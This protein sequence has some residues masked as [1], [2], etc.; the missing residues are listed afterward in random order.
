MIREAFAH[1]VL[2]VAIAAPGNNTANARNLEVRLRNV[3]ER[4]L[5]QPFHLFASCDHGTAQVAA[6]KATVSPKE[7]ATQELIK[8]GAAWWR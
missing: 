7:H 2:P 1:H 4:L 3:P 6:V 5:D 8:D